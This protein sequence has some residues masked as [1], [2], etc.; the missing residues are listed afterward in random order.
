VSDEG[1]SRERPLILVA[2]DNE[3]GR[4]LSRKF[5]ERFDFAVAEAADGDEAVAAFSPS[6]SGCRVSLSSRSARRV[7]ARGGPAKGPVDP[8]AAKIAA[9]KLSLAALHKVEKAIKNFEAMVAAHPVLGEK[10]E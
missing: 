7:C 2:D 10:L 3:T 1:A 8:G 9:Y 4:T 5:L 6:S